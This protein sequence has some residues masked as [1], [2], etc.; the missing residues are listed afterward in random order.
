MFNQQIIVISCEQ[1]QNESLLSTNVNV[2]RCIDKQLDYINMLNV[3]VGELH[4]FASSKYQ[5]AK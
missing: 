1:L 5:F 2:P 3:Q 4:L